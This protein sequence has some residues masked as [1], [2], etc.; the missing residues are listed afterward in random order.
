MNP[1]I[2]ILYVDDEPALL[3]ISKIFLERSEEFSVDTALSASAAV[4]LLKTENYDA[5]ISDYQ[6]PEIDGIDFLRTVRSS[7]NTVPFILFTGRGREEIVIQALNEGADF[8]VQKGTEPKSQF[9]ELGHKIRQAVQK[10]RAEGMLRERETQLRATL[11]STADGILTIDNHGRVIQA[12]PRFLDLWKIPSS[13]METGDDKILLDFVLDQLVNPGAF[14]KKIQSLYG[15]DAIDNDTLAFKDGRVVERNS[16]PMMMDGSCIGRVWSF[17]DV[18]ERKRSEDAL[19]ESEQRFRTLSDAAMDGIVIH[20]KGIVVD[21]NPKY[22]AMFGYAPEE[23]IG[24]NGPEIML[25]A[26]SLAAI[27]RWSKEGAG[28]TIDISCIRKDGTRFCGE[29]VSS[30]ILWLGKKHAVVHIRDVTAR[31]ESER[32]LKKQ[33]DEL[34]AAYEQLAATEEELRG[35]YNML[36][37]SAEDLRASEAK[38]RSLVEY[39]LE[40]ILI[41]DMRGTILFANNAAA[42]TI[43][44]E[45]S[46]YLPGRNVMEFIAPESKAD[47]ARDFIE[48]SEGHDGFPA[49]YTA[50]SVT[51]KKVLVECVGKLVTYEGEPADFLSLRDIT[52]RKMTEDALH[53]SEEKYRELVENANSL[54]LK[55]DKRGNVAFINE[56]AQQFFGYTADEIIGKSVMGTIVPETESG[57]ERDLGLMIDDIIHHPGNYIFNENENITRDG[58]RVWIRWHNKPIYEKK[59]VFF[60]M[61]SIG[62]DITERKRAEE[63]L[64]QVNRKLNL[65][66]GITRHDINNQLSVLQSFLELMAMKQPDLVHNKYFEE[67]GIASRRISSM[68]RF[69]AE[70]ESVGIN[71]PVWL[72]CR[73]LVETAALG[74]PLGG[75][76]VEN[77]LPAGAE[78]FAD[79]M[80]VKV[81]YNLID[82]AVRYGGKITT[83]RFS[84][85]SRDSCQ[86]LACSDDG[87]GIS[88][89]DKERIFERGFGKTTGLGLALAREILDITGIAISETGEPGSGARF[90]MNVPKTMWRTS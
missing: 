50:I 10:R 46:S 21:C 64:C 71:T 5:I 90:E 44:M 75:I 84:V 36:A 81:F 79:P 47:V 72:D 62:T 19:R 70:Y 82:N 80:I 31:R 61:F 18:T 16:S 58:N 86:V 33:R 34:N 57:S 32:L 26:E 74:V 37:K 73:S 15:S 8:Y 63:A 45:N 66:S 30:T 17:R 13:L 43:E 35:Q 78:V 11:E 22:A 89:K 14:L 83:I 39:S 23:I 41:L 65:L 68:I 53:E 85:E 20:N 38:F 59:G 87:D 7:G 9:A 48:V 51:G 69:T 27:T 42:R 6:M 1:A 25:T 49:H 52:G 4:N 60:G 56:F 28:G 54:I 3:D 55:W 40:G 12:N 24:R 2:R 76:I 29:A 77:D 67:V 88:G